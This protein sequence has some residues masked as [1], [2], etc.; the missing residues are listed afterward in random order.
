LTAPKL[1]AISPNKLLPRS[2]KKNTL[3][4]GSHM[5][6]VSVLF[7]RREGMKFNIKYYAETH[8]PMLRQKLGDACKG[9][10]FDRGVAV[11][12]QMSLRHLL[13]SPI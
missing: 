13:P 2:P 12:R 1:P 5:I 10:V 4:K 8:L 6:K 9:L 3:E 7:P 11:R